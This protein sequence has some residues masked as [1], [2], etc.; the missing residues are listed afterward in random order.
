MS[1]HWRR[2]RENKRRRPHVQC[3]PLIRAPRRAHGACKRA[4]NV[5]ATAGH[6]LGF[7][8]ECYQR[9]IKINKD[10]NE[11]SDLVQTLYVYALYNM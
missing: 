2:E 8:V 3:V 7:K 11:R 6:I 9:N 5:Q 10:E 1:D 4:K